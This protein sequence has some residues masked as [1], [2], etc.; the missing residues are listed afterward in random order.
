MPQAYCNVRRKEDYRLIGA[1]S[2][3][4]TRFVH[5]SHCWHCSFTSCKSALLPAVGPFFPFSLSLT[6]HFLDVCSCCITQRL[7]VTFATLLVRVLRIALH[8]SVASLHATLV[9]T[10]CP[11]AHMLRPTRLL[12]PCCAWYAGLLPQPLS[13]SARCAWVCSLP[14]SR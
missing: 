1:L 3:S 4:S 10:I 6:M 9:L 2:R 7:S 5:C 12:L 14:L 11:P 8:C 13:P